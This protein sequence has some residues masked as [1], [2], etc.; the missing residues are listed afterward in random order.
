MYCKWSGSQWNGPSQGVLIVAKC[1]VN[2]S[3]I[4]FLV[5]YI[6]V[7]IVAKCIVNINFCV[8]ELKLAWVLIVA[9]CIVNP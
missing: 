4:I 2:I 8:Y 6:T 3:V 1:I 7:L 5:I 9:K